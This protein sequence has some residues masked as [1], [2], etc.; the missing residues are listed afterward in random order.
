MTVKSNNAIAL[1]LVL[2]GCLIGSKVM[3]NNYSNNS[4]QA[5]M[6]IELTRETKCGV[7][8]SLCHAISHLI[9][10]IPESVIGFILL[11]VGLRKQ[12]NYSVNFISLVA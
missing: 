7:G 5:S 2:V 10:E 3:A 9:F 6:C 4:K 8:F 1:V 12:L 11:L